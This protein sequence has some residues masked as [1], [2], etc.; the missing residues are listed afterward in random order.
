MY[1]QWFICWAADVGLDVEKQ[2]EMFDS[3]Y[4]VNGDGHLDKIEF[5]RWV[6]PSNE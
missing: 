2:R 6:A 4:D 3:D 5:K 1:F